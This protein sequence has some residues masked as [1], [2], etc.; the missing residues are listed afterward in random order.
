MNLPIVIAVGVFAISYFFI[1]QEKIHKTI[2]VLLGSFL[3]GLCKIF[4]SAEGHGQLN[5]ILHF[6]DFNVLSLIIGMMII[7]RITEKSG[8]FTEVAMKLVRITK[9][10]MKLL[11]FLLMILTAFLTA[12]LSNVTTVMILTPIFL[13]ICYR[14]KLN[15]LPFFITE[16]L[17]SNIGGTATPIGDMTN[18]I[19][20]SKAGFSFTKVVSNLGPVVLIIAIV[21][22]GIATFVFRKDLKNAA[23]ESLA[24]LHGKSW[25]TNKKLMYQGL[26]ILA[27]VITGFIFHEQ[28]TMD[29]GMIALGGAMLLLLITKKEPREAFEM[30][31]WS[32]IFFFVGLFTLIGALEVTGVIDFLALKL[33]DLFGNNMVLLMMAIVFGSAVFSAFVDNIPFATAMI[34]IIFKIGDLTGMQ[35]DP[36]FWS[37]ALGACIGGSGTLVGASCNLV[38]AGIAEQNEV[39]LTFKKYFIYAFPIMLISVAIGA[40][41]LLLFQT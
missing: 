27:I 9:G 35:T 34:P 20:A 37:L 13:V 7:V 14:F 23:K 21:S 22:A 1:V 40:V 29:N 30:V 17:L 8:I 18:I 39:P 28:L 33:V 26:G 6:I 15:P 32:I 25:I 41:Y 31:E 38:V 10:N 36:L 19:I 16:I 12:L 5:E 11:F 4:P 3:L 2:I 24:D